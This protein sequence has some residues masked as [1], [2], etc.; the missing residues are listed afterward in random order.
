ML[1][2]DVID[3]A[4]LSIEEKDAPPRRAK[5]M[6]GSTVSENCDLCMAGASDLKPIVEGF[7]DKRTTIRS[8]GCLSNKTALTMVFK[9]IEA[10]KKAGA[11]ST[12]ITTTDITSCQ[13]SFSV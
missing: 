6:T 2:D 4:P 3:A 12:D 9:L 13:N 7:F 11:V 5:H 10:P 8:K 1:G